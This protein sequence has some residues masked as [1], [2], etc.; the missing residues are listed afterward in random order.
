[1]LNVLYRLFDAIGEHDLPAVHAVV[2]A[3]DQDKITIIDRFTYGLLLVGFGRLSLRL[4]EDQVI[5]IVDGRRL[6]LAFVRYI[7]VIL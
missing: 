2:D 6:N 5:L 1:M 4:A 7:S 3:I